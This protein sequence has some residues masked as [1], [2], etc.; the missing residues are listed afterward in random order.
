[1]VIITKRRR[2]SSV[3]IISPTTKLIALFTGLSLFTIGVFVGTKLF[4]P[5]YYSNYSS[6]STSS[7]NNNAAA[8]HPIVSIQ[9]ELVHAV[10][11]YRLQELADSLHEQYINAY[12]FPHVVIDNLLPQRVLQALLDE[13]PESLVGKEGCYQ[14]SRRCKYKTDFQYQQLKSNI[15][16][17]MDMGPMTREVIWFLTSGTFTKFL[18]QLSGIVGLLPDPQH[19]GGGIHMTAN[20]GKLNIHSDYNAKGGVALDRRVNFFLFLN[21]NWKDEYGGHL[22]LWNKELN[23]C[24][25]RIRPDL[26]RI[27]VFSTTDFTYH[28]HP[29]PLTAPDRRVRRS[30]ALYYYTNGRPKKDCIDEVCPSYSK[31][32][33]HVFDFHGTDWKEPQCDCLECYYPGGVKQEYT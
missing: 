6:S 4:S 33:M 5:S 1:M 12:P 31:D 9:E 27:V 25:A 15:N 14:K 21:P 13:I 29:H 28:G 24:G 20:K 11:P 19:D 22:E 10:N 30:I 23:K 16:D 3:I 7:L 2:A 32:R 8:S 18:S 26:G 17:E